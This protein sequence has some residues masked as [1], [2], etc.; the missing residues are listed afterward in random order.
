ML[1]LEIDDSEN[2]TKKVLGKVAQVDGL[3]LS[4]TQVDYKPWQDFQRW[5]SAGERRAVVPYAAVMVKLIQPVAVRLRRDVGQVICAIKAHAL[6]H[7]DQRDRGDDGQIIADID[8]DYDAVRK[9]MNAIIAEGSGVAVN[10]AI[11][12]TIDAVSKATIGMD[13]DQGADAKAIGKL[14]NL[15]RSAAWRRLS[16]ACDEGYVVNL[17][18]RPRMPGKYRTTGQK[19]E[20]MAILPP[21]AD[22]AEDYNTSL[23]LSPLKSM[24]SC[25]REEMAEVSLS[26]NECK[27]SVHTSAECDADPTSR[28]HECNRVQTD[29]ALVNQLDGNEKSTPVARVQGF[30]GESETHV[31]ALDDDLSISDFDQDLTLVCDHCGGPATPSSPV[32]LCAVDGEECHLHP[33]CRADWLGDLSIPPYLKR[34]PGS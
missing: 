23:S 33:K 13:E 4:A 19:I 24:H 1:S 15:D 12:E 14:L 10:P 30:S 2:Q 5:L 9:L 32:Q 18:Q 27:D 17:E 29:L 21:T 31:H 26:N 28:V 6:V 25:N 3:N 20:P 16:A 11:A 22:L 34:E 7:R 8:H